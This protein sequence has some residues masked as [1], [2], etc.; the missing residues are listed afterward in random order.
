MPTGPTST[1]VRLAWVA[2]CLFVGCSDH[3]ES[4]D[5]LPVSAPGSSREGDTVPADYGPDRLKYGRRFCVIVGID[6]YSVD[7]NDLEPLQHAENDAREFRDLLQA[8]FGFAPEHCSFLTDQE[9]TLEK[10]RKAL[11]Q[12]LIDQQ[13]TPDDAFLFFFAGHGLI[14]RSTQEGFLAACDSQRDKLQ[15]TCLSVSHL[16]DAI[17]QIPC[18]HKLVFLDSCY[19][20]TLFQKVT[21]T[22]GTP[23]NPPATHSL[24]GLGSGSIDEGPSRGGSLI[25]AASST[26]Q[27][28]DCFREPC[29]AGMSA[30]RLTPVADGLGLNRHSIF[31]SAL[32]REMHERSDS[33]RD[34]QAFTLLRVLIR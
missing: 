16:R 20:G 9:A 3:R 14:D 25:H 15:S 30:G 17:Q 34:D 7:H 11:G 10:I 6:D 33:E 29:F 21:V 2:L 26:D 24:P 23:T 1:M 31:T 4:E 12:V 28:Q 27:L 22:T 13:P 19:S 18:R 32:L 5:H 8:E